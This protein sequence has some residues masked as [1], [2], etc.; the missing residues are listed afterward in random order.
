[1]QHSKDRCLGPSEE[2]R[3]A[4]EPRRYSRDLQKTARQR[5]LERPIETVAKESQG[6]EGIPTTEDVGKGRS[7]LENHASEVGMDGLVSPC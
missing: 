2:H 5:G 3:G 7:P 1:M 6:Y 4:Y